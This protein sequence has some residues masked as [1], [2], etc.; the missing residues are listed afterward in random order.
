MASNLFPDHRCYQKPP[1]IVVA[2]FPERAYKYPWGLWVTNGIVLNN[3]TEVTNG[4]M[5]TYFRSVRSVMASAM[6]LRNMEMFEDWPIALYADGD[7]FDTHTRHELLTDA[8]IIQYTFI[9]HEQE[10]NRN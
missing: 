7:G 2:A 4:S 8:E 1:E 5:N 3:A 6:E 10:T 9:Y